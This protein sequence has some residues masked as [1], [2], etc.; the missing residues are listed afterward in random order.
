MLRFADSAGKYRNPKRQRGEWTTAQLSPSL[1]LRVTMAGIPH[2]KRNII[3]ARGSPTTHG[4]RTRDHGQFTTQST[5][6]NPKSK[7]VSPSCSCHQSSCLLR[8]PRFT[9]LKIS[10]PRSSCNLAFLPIALHTDHGRL[11]T[12]SRSNPK[13]KIQNHLPPT[14]IHSSLEIAHAERMIAPS[15]MLEKLF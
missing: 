3:R 5:I 14:S 9:R 13:S 11:T 2:R 4:R 1:T 15:R 10:P 6:A 7:T 8:W 12:H